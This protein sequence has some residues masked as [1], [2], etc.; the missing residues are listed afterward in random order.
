MYTISGVLALSI[1]FAIPTLFEHEVVRVRIFDEILSSMNI[2]ID[3]L[4]L[5]AMDM[6][7]E[8]IFITRSPTSTVYYYT[9]VGF[10]I[11]THIILPWLALAFFNISTYVQVS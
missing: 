1:L 5:E 10:N 8:L 6:P 2:T 3:V 7:E 4:K 11:L 9:M